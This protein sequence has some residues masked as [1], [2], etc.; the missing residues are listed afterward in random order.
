MI[1]NLGV[2]RLLFGSDYPY[3]SPT[4]TILSVLKAT[5]S[6]IEREKIFSGNAKYLLRK[7]IIF[8]E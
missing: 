5:D 1:G 7:K 6:N 8:I 4:L 3:L 2:N